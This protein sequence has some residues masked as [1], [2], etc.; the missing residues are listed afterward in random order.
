MPSDEL[1]G[2]PERGRHDSPFTH[3]HNRQTV[4]EGLVGGVV[5]VPV[6]VAEPYVVE[7]F[8]DVEHGK[9]IAARVRPVKDVPVAH[10]ST[11]RPLVGHDGV[12]V[13]F[14]AFAYGLRRFVPVVGDLGVGLWYEHE[15]RMHAREIDVRVCGF[16]DVGREISP[17]T[18]GP[19]ETKG[20]R[21]L[22][23]PEHPVAEPEVRV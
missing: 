17:Q 19:L 1:T 12:S 7:R 18:T 9:R 5:P 15:D 23:H 16:Y 4:T 13:G 21:I 8:V 2:I 10:P 3:R 22:R 6:N 14:T 20:A 11:D